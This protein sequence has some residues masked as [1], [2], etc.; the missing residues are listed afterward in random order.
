VCGVSANSAFYW[1]RKRTI[2]GPYY[3]FI[4]YSTYYW[5][6][7]RMRKQTIRG[8]YVYFHQIGH[9]LDEKFG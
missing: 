6:E 7:K 3:I 5:M 1:M 9:A 8:Q 2:P 4:K